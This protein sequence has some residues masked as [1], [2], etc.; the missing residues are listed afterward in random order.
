MLGAGWAV[1]TLPHDLPHAKARSALLVDEGGLQVQ[2]IAYSSDS[3]DVGWSSDG[4][5]MSAGGQ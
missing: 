4:S 1:K 3:P 2:V 5:H